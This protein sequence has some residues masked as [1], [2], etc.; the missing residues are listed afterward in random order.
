MDM[1]LEMTSTDTGRKSL[2]PPWMNFIKREVTLFVSILE[3][4]YS[5]LDYM[6]DNLWFIK[7]SITVCVT[8]L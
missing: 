6:V 5:S 8:D 7:P 2:K 4:Q 1:T 3:F